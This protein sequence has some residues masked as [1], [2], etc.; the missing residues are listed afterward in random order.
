[1]TTRQ[2]DDAAQDAAP[3]HPQAADLVLVARNYRT[4]RGRDGEIDLLVRDPRDRTLVVVEV[5]RDA[6]AT[7]GGTAGSMA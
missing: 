2:R 4:P 7:H 5:R 6:S 1:M 3:A